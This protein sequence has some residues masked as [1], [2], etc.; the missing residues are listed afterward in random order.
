[1]GGPLPIDRLGP[2]G[3]RDCGV[4]RRGLSLLTV[5][6]S[7]TFGLIAAAQDALP[8]TAVVLSSTAPAR[9]AM[10]RNG[11]DVL[12][13]STGNI[14]A[15]VEGPSRGNVAP[16]ARPR[17]TRLG[18][19]SSPSPNLRPRIRPFVATGLLLARLSDPSFGPRSRPVEALFRPAMRPGDLLL[20]DP[21]RT[22][23]GATDLQC[24]AVAIY[25]EARDQSLDGQLA[26]A[27][28]ILNRAREP[29]RWGARPCDI[30]IPGQFSFLSQRGWFPA[31]NNREAW[32]IAVEMA[33]EALE[34]GPSSLVGQADHYHTRA[35]Q[36]D[37]RDGMERV[38]RIGDHIFY[39]DASAR[40]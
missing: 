6:L 17:D 24:L 1:M 2:A 31:I 14:P 5:S 33:R 36:P 22:L 29:R 40:G 35:V 20:P 10:A 8:E 13:S 23:A 34:R 27:S 37:W 9:L 11:P 16:S 38:I 12:A 7:L 25:H 26:V 30:V 39:A 32:A 18:P 4:A 3:R 21:P 19:D 15:S 28:V